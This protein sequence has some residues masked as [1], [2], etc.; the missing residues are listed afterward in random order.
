M[1]Y[2]HFYIF[3]DE[4]NLP[5]GTYPILLKPITQEKF[6]CVIDW[7]LSVLEPLKI[8]SMEKVRND[9]EELGEGSDFY[10]LKH[11][12]KVTVYII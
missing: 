9:L 1:K 8:V 7:D 2:S 12:I 11:Q 3:S 6:D 10:S 5:D 4:T